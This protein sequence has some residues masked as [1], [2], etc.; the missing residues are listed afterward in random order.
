MRA[1]LLFLIIITTVLA[2]G[3]CEDEYDNIHD[4]GDTQNM[5]TG[6]P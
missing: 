3:G 2:F 6:F 4:S 1:L 5:N